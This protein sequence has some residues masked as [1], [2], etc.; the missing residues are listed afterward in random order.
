M[1]GTLVQRAKIGETNEIVV[2]LK[3]ICNSFIELMNFTSIV[4]FCEMNVSYFHIQHLAY[5]P[6]RVV[7]RVDTIPSQLMLWSAAVY[8]TTSTLFFG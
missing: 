5:D 7:G 4:R 6:G 1:A 2:R 3:R 8:K